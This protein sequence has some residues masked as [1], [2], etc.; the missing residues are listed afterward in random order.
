MVHVA[1]GSAESS[2]SEAL[3]FGGIT[4]LDQSTDSAFAAAKRCV[5]TS[6]ANV[7]VRDGA[8]VVTGEIAPGFVF[9][10][11]GMIWMLGEQPMHPVDFSGRAVI[12]FRTH[13]DGWEYPVMLTSSTEPVE[14]PSSVRFVAPEE[15]AQVELRPEGILRRRRKSLRDWRFGKGRVGPFAL[16]VDEVEVR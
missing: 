9:P 11:A 14:P 10:W 16:E 6:G 8:L 5:S 15:W 7:A 3:L 2:L 4:V 13:G 12:R 1:A